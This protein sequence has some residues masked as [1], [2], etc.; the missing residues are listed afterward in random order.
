[1]EKYY[2]V[3]TVCFCS[4]RQVGMPFETLRSCM[5]YG[6]RVSVDKRVAIQVPRSHP[7]MIF[8][9]HERSNRYRINESLEF[10]QPTTDRVI[11]YSVNWFDYLST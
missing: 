3:S 2:V 5:R 1:M 7:N 11:H 8:G 9:C 6:K 4:I 10:F